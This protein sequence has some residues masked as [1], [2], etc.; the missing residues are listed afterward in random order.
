MS[1]RAL[2]IR[3]FPESPAMLLFG[4]PLASLSLAPTGE[5]AR[6]DAEHA[7]FTIFTI[8]GDLIHAREGTCL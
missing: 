4:I 7:I 5:P 8:F 2:Q 1:F 3:Y 6:G